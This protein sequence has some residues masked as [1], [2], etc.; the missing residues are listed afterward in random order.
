VCCKLTG[1]C[2]TVVSTIG[3]ALIHV[4]EYD[5]TD[6]APCVIDTII[7]RVGQTEHCNSRL[8]SLFCVSMYEAECCRIV[9]TILITIHIEQ[10]KTILGFR[11]RADLTASTARLERLSHSRIASTSERGLFF[12]LRIHHLVLIATCLKL[13]AI[14]IPRPILKAVTRVLKILFCDS[15]N[16]VGFE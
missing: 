11:L 16:T 3:K 4:R 12:L 15:V 9:L 1:C 13:L 10:A 2:S 6:F 5:R 14:A 7:Q 8:C